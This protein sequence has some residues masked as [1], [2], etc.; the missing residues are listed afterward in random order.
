M[1]KDNPFPGRRGSMADRITVLEED[2]GVIDYAVGDVH[3]YRAHMEAALRWCA[4]DARERGMLGRVHLLGDYGDR[5]PDTRGVIERLMRG[6]DEDWMTWHPVRGNHDEVLT[7]AWRDPYDENAFDWWSHG[8]QQLLVSYGWRPLV[9]GLPDLLADW[10]PVEHIEFLEGLPLAN[11]V[12]SKLFVHA[13]IRPGN[14]LERQTDRDLMW[15]RTEFLK[16]KGDHG[17]TVIHGHS[18]EAENPVD[19]G[20]R[21]AM[22]SGCFY[23]DV[24]SACAFDPGEPK[25]RFRRFDETDIAQA[26]EREDADPVPS[27]GPRF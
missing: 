20:N 16:F 10:I 12:G 4:E 21:I 7:R 3:G 22:D 5:G 17:L 26:A 13:G 19:H 6:P 24:L 25:P 27:V 15:I 2:P 18:P 23:T 8:G 14:P 1:E 9:H 11:L